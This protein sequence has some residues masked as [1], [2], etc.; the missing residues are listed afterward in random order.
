MFIDSLDALG[1]QRV[2]SAANIWIPGG[3]ERRCLIDTLSVYPIETTSIRMIVAE[4][5]IDSGR[6]PRTTALIE[7]RQIFGLPAAW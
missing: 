5:F 1:H 7:A 6:M 4:M 3:V 2:R